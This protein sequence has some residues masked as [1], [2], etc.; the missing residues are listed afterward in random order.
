LIN[1]KGVADYKYDLPPSPQTWGRKII[2]SPPNLGD[3]GGISGHIRYNKN[4]FIPQFSNATK[5][6]CNYA[7]L[8]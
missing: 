5:N 8:Q 6:I 4:K 3:L 7:T 2:S 1:K